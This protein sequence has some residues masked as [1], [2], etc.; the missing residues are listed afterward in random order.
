MTAGESH[1]PKVVAIVEGLPAGLGIDEAAVQHELAR[2]QRGYGRGQRMRSIEHDEPRFTAGLRFGETCG[3]PVLVEIEN[4]DHL[5]WT[6]VMSPRPPRTDDRALYRPRPG[7]A[8]LVGGLKYA[9][10]DLRD[11]LERASARNTA[12]RVAAGALAKALL[13]ELGVSVYS[14]VTRIGCAAWTPEGD[15]AWADLA[16]RAEQSDVRCPDEA[17]AS[18]MRQEVDA[19]RDAGDT[20]GGAFVVVATGLPTGWG[21][22]A[23]WDRKLDGRL[24]QAVMSIPAVKAVSFGLG[25]DSGVRRGSQVHDEIRFDEARRLD[26]SGGYVRATNRAGG[27]EGGVT[28]GA[29]LVMS[30]TMKPISTLARPL[31]SVDIRDKQASVAGYERSD[32]C[33][34]PACGVIAEAAVAFCLADAALEAWGGDTMAD[35]LAHRDHVFARYARS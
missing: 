28:N 15:A 3:A 4:A 14:L 22:Y 20:V 29:D 16:G 31:A 32:I 34:V 33:A 6:A 11:A 23:D 21:S 13:A 19:A 9:R 2:R 26:G 18:A 27:L 8:D 17:T 5:K 25:E 10:S 1:G 12:A 35:L 24:A 30:A 7:H